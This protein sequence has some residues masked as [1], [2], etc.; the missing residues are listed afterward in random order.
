MSSSTER[1]KIGWY[2]TYLKQVKGIYSLSLLMVLLSVV[3]LIGVTYVQ[4]SL[5]DTVFLNKQYG[6]FGG[7]LAL[8]GVLVVI[9]IS[10][11]VAKDMLLERT[12]TGLKILLREAFMERLYRMP[13]KQYKNQ[14]I[15]DLSSRMK[16]LL[17]STD[18]FVGPLP[19]GIES[20]LSMLILTVLIGKESIW[21]LASIT[22]LSVIYT[23]LH[24]HFARQNGSITK[25]I[26]EAQSAVAVQIEEG[27][28]ATREV[29]AFHNHNWEAKKIR[30]SFTS[31]FQAV[32]KQAKLKNR[33]IFCTDPFR[34]GTILLV[35]IIGGENVLRGEM[36]IG[37]FV[38]IYLLTNQL[39][40]A[41]QGGFQLLS[42]L[43]EAKVTIERAG[44][45]MQMDFVDEGVGSI[46]GGIQQITF[47]DVYFRYRESTG[48]VLSGFTLDIPVGSKVALVGLSGCGKS[49][50]AQLLSGLYA[51]DSGGIFINQQPLQAYRWSE[52]TSKMSFVMQEPYLFPDTIQT[53]IKL[54]RDVPDEE[55]HEACEISQLSQVIGKLPDGYN[56]LVGERG[57]TLSGG[58]RQRLVVARAILQNPEVLI[59]DEATSALDMETERR[60][61]QQLDKRRKGK[62]T[63]VIAHRLSTIQNSDLIVIMEKG[64]VHEMGSHADLLEKSLIYQELMNRNEVP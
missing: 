54:G 55:L 25:Q 42:S 34:W 28:A 15:G 48:E 35:L 41:F 44:S 39:T 38:V 43:S 31:L 16:Q 23:G 9:Y 8:F 18:F 17:D 46:R 60:I 47:Q 37:H 24:K 27:I 45:I 32:M 61:M 33:Q 52:W 11:W 20:L 4:R 14:R 58:E 64:K 56:T 26:R 5:I 2:L 21:L 50:T 22:I 62:T 51:P 12:W 6:E 7:I 40:D 30:Y 63:I 57:I 53:N 3:S 36:S 49:T 19:N 1:V 29:V 59:L 13:T 10:S